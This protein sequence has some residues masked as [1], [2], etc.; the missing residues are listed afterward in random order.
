MLMID[1]A[2]IAKSFDKAAATYEAGADIQRQA[3]TLLA[4]R[5]SAIVDQIP[6]GPALELGCGTGLFTAEILKYCADRDL[7][8]SDISPRM[9]RE[10]RERIKHPVRLAVI[11]GDRTDRLEAARF[12]L[13]ASAFSAQW[14]TDIRTAFDGIA[15]ALAPGGYFLFSF[16]T[17]A[18]FPEWKTICERTG[19]PFTGNNLPTAASI[20]NYCL[21]RG[22][23][24][25]LHATQIRLHYPTAL[26]FFKTLRRVGAT[27]RMQPRVESRNNFDDGGNG[28]HHPDY[29]PGD[30]DSGG[31]RLRRLLRQWDRGAQG[32]IAVTYDIL[33][34]HLRRNL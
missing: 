15:N 5:L 10:C 32:Q 6:A 34:G 29:R 31:A 11:D 30:P 28:N 14:F 7:T 24:S 21:K 17:A 2:I 1:Q 4:S 3:A 8:I 23:S 33:Y 16:P 22:L 27:T 12:A 19:I 18:S 13:I 26:D 9:L 25:N 20:H